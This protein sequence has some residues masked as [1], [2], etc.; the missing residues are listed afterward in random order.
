MVSIVNTPS[1]TCAASVSDPS[2]L[3]GDVTGGEFNVPRLKLPVTVR[4]LWASVK[5]TDAVVSRTVLQSAASAK[6]PLFE[7]LETR[8][9]PVQAPA[10]SGGGAGVIGASGPPPHARPDS[11]PTMPMNAEKREQVIASSLMRAALSSGPDQREGR[12]PIPIP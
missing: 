8:Y 3:T 7:Q 12:R 10:K 6:N 5:V 9:V 1:R 11:Q 2:L 4:S